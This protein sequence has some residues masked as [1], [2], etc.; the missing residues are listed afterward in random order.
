M[1]VNNYDLAGPF[2]HGGMRCHE[3]DGPA[4]IDDNGFAGF[5][6][7]QLRRVPTSREDVRE[8]HVIILFFD[9]VLGQFEAVRIAIRH[10]QKFSLSA[11]IRAHASVTIGSTSH[12]RIGGEA[13]PRQSSLAVFAETA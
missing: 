5:D 8:H 10:A 2:D 3:A 9:S 12:A 1:A 13:K 7:R 11:I 4:A 6:T